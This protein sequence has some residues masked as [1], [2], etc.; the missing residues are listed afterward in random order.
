M[1]ALEATEDGREALGMDVDVDTFI[2]A[3]FGEEFA[4]LF[5]SALIHG[6]YAADS[7]LLSVRASFP[8]LWNASKCRGRQGHA[9]GRGWGYGYEP[10]PKGSEGLPDYGDGY[11]AR[12]RPP[13]PLF[14]HH[15]HHHRRWG[16]GSWGHDVCEDVYDLGGI[17]GLVKGASVYS[18][19]E[20]ME[21]I[22]RALEAALVKHPKVEVRKGE[23][24]ESIARD[25]EKGGFIVR[26]VIPSP[27]L[28][29]TLMGS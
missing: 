16:W 22:V 19:T 28:S 5:A 3:K 7:R 9:Q 4:R 24:V 2:K 8:S 11:Y 29:F 17:K 21:T 14:H 23:G 10:A 20:G 26:P 1:K 13:P 15:H 12:R 27:L 6:I 25:T 18:F